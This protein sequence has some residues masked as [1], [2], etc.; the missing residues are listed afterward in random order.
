M[1]ARG[2]PSWL[3]GQPLPSVRSGFAPRV[4]STPIARPVGQEKALGSGLDDEIFVMDHV[5]GIRFDSAI[6]LI[7]IISDIGPC[8]KTDSKQF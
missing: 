3:R 5:Y 8:L 1:P 7:N 4:P 6:D 2:A